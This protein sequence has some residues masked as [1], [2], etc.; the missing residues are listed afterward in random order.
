[1]SS[2]AIRKAS[3]AILSATLLVLGLLA[4]TSQQASAGKTTDEP[5]VS[6]LAN[7]LE[8]SESDAAAIAEQQGQFADVATLIQEKFPNDYV[9]AEWR[10]DH[11]VITVTDAAVES[12]TTLVNATAENVD[13]VGSDGVG[14]APRTELSGRI[15]DKLVELLEDGDSVD[16]N[17]ATG[18]VT[19]GLVNN[20]ETRQREVLEG[21]KQILGDDVIIEFTQSEGPV[22]FYDG[23]E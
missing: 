23:G 15:M 11:G 21:A 13:V 6:A 20:T 19:I 7:L 5:W 18:I 9:G 1:M 17:P 12:A 8:V 3:V 22:L 4:M 10:G 2:T 16:A 14:L